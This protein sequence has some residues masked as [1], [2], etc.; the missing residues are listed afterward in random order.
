MGPWC[1]P[2]MGQEVVASQGPQVGTH[3]ALPR[4]FKQIVKSARANGTAGPTEDHTDDFLGCL[5]IPIRVSGGQG[6]VPRAHLWC[7][8]L[9]GRRWW[10]CP[11]IPPSLSHPSWA[12]WGHCAAGDREGTASWGLLCPGTHEC[13]PARWPVF[14]GKQWSVGGRG[15][16]NGQSE[17]PSLRR[18]RWLGKTAGSSW[19]RAPAPPAC[20]GTASWSSS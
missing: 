20:R 18:C 9:L 11:V 4:Y 17:P 2:D 19:N 3:P 10:L 6:L 12:G 1:P 15:R 5:N 14:S 16:R 7:L 8:T 13:S